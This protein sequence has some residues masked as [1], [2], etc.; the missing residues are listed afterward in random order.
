MPGHGRGCGSTA[1]GQQSIA[2]RAAAQFNASPGFTPAQEDAKASHRD[3]RQRPDSISSGAALTTPLS[4]AS[5][6]PPSTTES[7][8]TWAPPLIRGNHRVVVGDNASS[9]DTAFVL[10]QALLLPEDMQKEAEQNLDRLLKTFMVSNI[11]V[12]LTLLFRS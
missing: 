1:V 4:E 3:K 11:K 5:L 7:P 8:S 9:S 10:S 2:A 6:L 12:I